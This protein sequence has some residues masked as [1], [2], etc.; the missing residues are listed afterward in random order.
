MKPV[1]LLVRICAILCGIAVTLACATVG[2]AR[3]WLTGCRTGSKVGAAKA[4]VRTIE[5]VLFEYRAVEFRWPTTADLVEKRYLS[6]R[7]LVDP[8]GTIIVY[9]CSGDDPTVISAG[10]D[11]AFGTEDDIKS[12]DPE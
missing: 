9:R 5:Q 2:F 12:P 3:V 6:P 8:W 10:P 4:R 7:E 11:R 1:R